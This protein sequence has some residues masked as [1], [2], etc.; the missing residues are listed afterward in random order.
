[1]GAIP[2]FQKSPSWKFM[3]EKTDFPDPTNPYD[4][5]SEQK[6]NLINFQGDAK[7][8]GRKMG[9]LNYSALPNGFTNAYLD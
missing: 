3:P 8:R 7:F 6:V 2:Q 5:V 1:M 4:F 9:D